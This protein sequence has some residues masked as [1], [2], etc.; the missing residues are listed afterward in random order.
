[1]KLAILGTGKIVQEGALPALKNVPEIEVIA[2][3]ARQHSK[4]VAENLAKEY[5]IP[6]VVTEYAEI[7]QDESVDFVYI[8]LVN[9]VHYEYAKQALLAGKNVIVEKPF[10][11]TAAEVKEISELALAKGLYVFEAV[12][13]LHLPNFQ[14]VKASLVKIGRI[15]M[16]TANYSQYSSRYDRYLQGEVL[17]AFDPAKFG[18]A[19]TDI[20]IYN[21]NIIIALFDSPLNTRYIP[22]L[23]FNGVDTSGVLELRY[24]DFVAIAIGAKDSDSPSF[25]TIQ[26]EKGWIRV[27]GAPNEL[28]AVE[29]SVRSEHLVKRYEL[30][31]YDNRMIHEFKEFALTFAKRDYEKMKIGLKTSLTVLETVEK[32]RLAGKLM[33]VDD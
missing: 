5:S 21:I 23:G 33:P 25:F 1:M 13:S 30:N 12:T 24:Q 32:A 4:G 2:I 10:A 27:I 26:G 31:K 19:L 3:Y 14:I 28:K 6:K 7:L 15:K 11:A 22:N 17:P 16:V 9:S 8:G 18:G 20:N 29:V